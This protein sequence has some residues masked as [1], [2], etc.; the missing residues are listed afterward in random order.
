MFVG[1]HKAIV[2]PLENEYFCSSYH[3][4]QF[5]N[6]CK[7]VVNHYLLYWVSE[8]KASKCFGVFQQAVD[9]LKWNFIVDKK[10]SDK[11]LY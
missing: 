4:V 2:V 3:L 11:I 6:L 8:E 7:N 1:F 10:F 9:S 5:V